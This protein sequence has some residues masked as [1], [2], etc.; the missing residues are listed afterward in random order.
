[1]ELCLTLSERARDFDQIDSQ[2]KRTG[3]LVTK[4]ETE[5]SVPRTPNPFLE[6]QVQQTLDLIEQPT[7]K[8]FES[9][10]KVCLCFVDPPIPFVKRHHVLFR[11]V[12]RSLARPPA[13]GLPVLRRPQLDRVFLQVSPDQRIKAIQVI[14]EER[15][16]ENGLFI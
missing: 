5:S 2:L 14:P 15:L 10:D 7:V 9:A 8:R 16:N 4:H 13:P 12:L 11:L 3:L 6:R 1:M